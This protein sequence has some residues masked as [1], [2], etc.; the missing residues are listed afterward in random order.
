MLAFKALRRHVSRADT[1]HYN[2]INSALCLRKRMKSKDWFMCSE[3]CHV[4]SHSCKYAVS[5]ENHL[6]SH[7]KTVLLRPFLYCVL[8]ITYSTA[9]K[10]NYLT[11]FHEGI[12]S[13]V[14]MASSNSLAIQIFVA[15]FWCRNSGVL[16]FPSTFLRSFF[17]LFHYF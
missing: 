6:L 12:K 5:R 8:Y 15:N 9:L 14:F 7:Y 10:V 4:N 3:S 13:L 1:I 17:S 2:I 11:L 16:T